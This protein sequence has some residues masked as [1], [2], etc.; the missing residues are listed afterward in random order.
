M[1]KLSNA[2]NLI[3]LLSDSEYSK[4]DE[5]AYKLEVSKRSIR[6]YKNELE[7]AGIYIKSKTGRYGGYKLGK[8]NKKV[9]DFIEK[10]KL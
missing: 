4:I 2:I 5:L 1:S 7:I 3:T 6:T 9:I 10:T 8:E